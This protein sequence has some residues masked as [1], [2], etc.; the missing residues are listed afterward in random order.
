M[1]LEG[2]KGGGNAWTA[3]DGEY[4]ITRGML[5]CW[6]RGLGDVECGWRGTRRESLDL[7][8]SILT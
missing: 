8:N 5:V 7:E 6:L 2:T 4:S 3:D 1:S